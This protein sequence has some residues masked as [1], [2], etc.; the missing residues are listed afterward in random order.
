MARKRATKGQYKKSDQERKKRTTTGK[1]DIGDTERYEP[2]KGDASLIVV[3]YTVTIPNHPDRVPVGDLWCR[4][5]VKIHYSVGVEE[6][7]FICPKTVGKRCPI[8]ED[9]VRRLQEATTE[10][11][12]DAA[13]NLKPQD[14]ELYNILDQDNIGNGVRF[15]DVA[16]GNFGNLFNEEIEHGQEKFDEFYDPDEPF[17]VETRFKEDKFAGN[18]FVKAAKIDFAEADPMEDEWL[19]SAVSLDICSV[20]FEYA[21]IEAIYLGIDS[22]EEGEPN[23]GG[24]AGETGDT[25]EKTRSGRKRRETPKDDGDAGGDGGTGDGGEGAS[26]SRRK[27][28][29]AEEKPAASG[30]RRNKPSD[31]ED[32]P[33]DKEPESK[34]PDEKK[35]DEKKPD[36][37]SGEVCPA[38][39]VFG[40]DFDALEACEKCNLWEKCADEYDAQHAASK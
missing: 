40:K 23:A 26:T 3:P 35:P 6:Q 39:G 34:K 9:R 14:R 8:C 16:M 37:G 15:W 25:P 12:K 32:V 33:R 22:G 10:E 27:R 18:K 17:S 5:P 2:E 29:P 13:W 24:E 28:K 31:A 19:E 4:F 36:T 38:N 30:R 7:S 20:I 11:E 1:Y 21:E